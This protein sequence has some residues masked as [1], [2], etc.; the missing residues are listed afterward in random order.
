MPRLI[1]SSVAVFLALSL[2]VASP[3]ADSAESAKGP[4]PPA[5]AKK[6]NYWFSFGDSYTQTWFNITGP[7]PN[8]AN[9]IGNP[10]YPGWTS[11]GGENWVGYVTTKYN[12]TK[13]Y[14]YNF[15]YG[16]AVIDDTLVTPW[17]PNLI[18]MD[19]QVDIF[20]DNLASKPATTPWTSKNS[21]FSFW[22]GI[23]DI[24]N[25]FW[26]PGDR[27]DFSDVLMNRYFELVQKLY[28]VG[29]RNFLFVNVP[30]LD[31]SPLQ[32]ASNPESQALEKAVIEGY[33]TRLVAKAKAFQKANKGVTLY[34]WDSNKAFT[35][36]LDNPQAYGFKDATSYGPGDDIFWGDNYHP[37]SAAHKFFGEEVG[38]QVLKH[39]IW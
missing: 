24:G 25:S 7:L 8:D 17:Q 4:K 27:G 13:L 9:P 36:I 35:R 18:H 5:P 20:L 23:N 33:N 38:R 21:L 10:E 30:P 1:L 29:A 6:P 32:L 15:A 12:N 26:L 34:F 3:F 19:D 2:A 37:S 14:T 39:T 11:T 31:R 28:N 16:G 22:I